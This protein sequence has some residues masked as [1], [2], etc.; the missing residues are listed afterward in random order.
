MAKS[1]LHET[2]LPYV[3]WG[4]A[5]NTAVYLLNRCPTKVVKDLTPFEG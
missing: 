5:V 2:E 1:M 4:E 3:F